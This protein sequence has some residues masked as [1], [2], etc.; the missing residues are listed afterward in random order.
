MKSGLKYKLFLRS[1]K[2]SVRNNS[3]SVGF[4]HAGKIQSILIVNES[5]FENKTLELIFGKELRCETVYFIPEKREKENEEKNIFK[6]D[7]NWW[8]I[9]SDKYIKNLLEV[10]F[11]LLINNTK[12]E[13][14]ALEYFCARSNAKFKV[15]RKNRYSIYD[16]IINAPDLDNVSYLKEIQKVITNFN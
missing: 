14:G 4:P 15:A 13:H 7:L 3:R 12:S 16:L 9:P 11:D 8:G 10:P 2:K 6:S 1:I 5:S